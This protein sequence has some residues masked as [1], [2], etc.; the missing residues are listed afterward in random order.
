MPRTRCRRCAV[1]QVSTVHRATQHPQT[2]GDDRGICPEQII[3]THFLPAELLAH[4]IKR[5]RSVPPVWVQVTD[6]DLHRMWV[7]TGVR[8]YFAAS[9]EIAFR[10]TRRGI[11]RANV[12]VIGIPIMPA[13]SQNLD[14]AECARE[15][16]IKADKTTLLHMSGGAGIAGGEQ[17]IES[18]INTGGWACR[19]ITGSRRPSVLSCSRGPIGQNTSP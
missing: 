2:S 6:F 18:G 7:Q 5:H 10:M 14:R 11:P 13:F 8:G 17:M 19:W 15:L 16:G 9:D 1:R 12:R 3:C 4:D